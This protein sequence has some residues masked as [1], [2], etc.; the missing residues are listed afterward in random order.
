MRFVSP[1]SERGVTRVRIGLVDD[2]GRLARAG[3]SCSRPALTTRVS[4]RGSPVRGLGGKQSQ[5]GLWEPC[6]I[7]RQNH[8][9]PRTAASAII[10]KKTP[11]R[12]GVM[13]G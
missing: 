6:R 11:P 8:G 2:S 12:F 13:A 7:F 10:Q 1:E 3:S 5:V 4:S 9:G